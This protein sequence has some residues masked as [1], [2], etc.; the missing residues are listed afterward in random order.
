MP[1]LTAEAALADLRQYVASRG[2]TLTTTLFDV[3]AFVERFSESLQNDPYPS[4]FLLGLLRVST[5]FR[6]VVASLGG[7][8]DAAAEFTEDAIERDVQDEYGEW[9]LYSAQQYRD[10]ERPALIDY[11]IEAAHIDNRT[12]LRVRDLASALMRYELHLE[13]TEGALGQ[14]I[15][16]SLR[17]PFLTL[18][19]IVQEFDESLNVRL[20]DLRR[21]LRGDPAA[22]L[23]KQVIDGIRKLLED[24]PRVRENGFVI[25]PFA[26]TPRNEEIHAAILD[27]LA[28]HGLRALRADVT[29][30]DSSLLG[31]VEVYMH[32][33]G[34]A[35]AVY[36][37]NMNVAYEAGYVRALG[38]PVCLLTERNDT[39]QIDLAGLLRVNFDGEDVRLSVIDALSR[40]L[41]EQRIVDQEV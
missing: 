26:P 40:W 30:Y 5:E 6:D 24:F 16:H 25:M 1:Q 2:F 41:I 31:N 39:V 29:A 7:D 38:K 9:P 15:E 18:A 33:C 11:T 4:T 23:P 37:P 27:A 28:A 14:W 36:E 10:R 3:F 32:G 34:F 21:A 20:V 17:A 13:K 8:P 35:I 22:R 12:E 19:H